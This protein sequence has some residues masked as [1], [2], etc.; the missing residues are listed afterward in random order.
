MCEGLILCPKCLKG[1]LE[2]AEDAIWKCLR[3][4]AILL[5]LNLSY[6]A[7]Q[8]EYILWQS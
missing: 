4:G 2:E 7:N 5:G 1:T 3:C 8:E 6:P